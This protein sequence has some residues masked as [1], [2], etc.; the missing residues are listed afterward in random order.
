MGVFSM[1]LS[2]AQDEFLERLQSRHKLLLVAMKED[3]SNLTTTKGGE[4]MAEI[5]V[6]T[7]V[8]VINLVYSEDL[9]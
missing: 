4:Q 8:R 1:D 2:L 7:L 3:F 5:A 9:D 6:K